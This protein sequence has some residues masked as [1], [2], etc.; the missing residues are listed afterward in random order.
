MDL[1]QKELA[2]STLQMID[3]G[4]LEDK[5]KLHYDEIRAELGP[6]V[7]VDEAG[8]VEEGDIVTPI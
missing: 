2:K 7:C 8:D 5:Q 3:S 4:E 1:D 6:I